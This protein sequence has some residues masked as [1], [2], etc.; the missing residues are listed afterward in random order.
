MST[1]VAAVAI[2]C[3]VTTDEIQNEARGVRQRVP[4]TARERRPQK[5]PQRH[6][7]RPRL[8]AVSDADTQQLVATEHRR[9]RDE[10]AEQ[11]GHLTIVA[12]NSIYPSSP[13][14][15]AMAK[16]STTA[17]ERPK[18]LDLRRTSSQSRLPTADRPEV[19][20]TTS[21]AAGVATA[22]RPEDGDRVESVQALHG[23][24]TVKVS[25]MPGSEPRVEPVNRKHDPRSQTP[26]SGVVV[27][28][29]DQRFAAVQPPSAISPDLML[30]AGS[31]GPAFHIAQTPTKSTIVIIRN[32]ASL[33]HVG[34]GGGG[35]VQPALTTTPS[36]TTPRDDQPTPFT[37]SPN[38]LQPVAETGT[39]TYHQ[40]VVGFAATS[41]FVVP[42]T[43]ATAAAAG[44]RP[45]TPTASDEM[46]AVGLNTGVEGERRR[47][48][49]N[50]RTLTAVERTAAMTFQP[51][52]SSNQTDVSEL[53]ERRSNEVSTVEPSLPRNDV[54]LDDGSRQAVVHR[55]AR[56][57]TTEDHIIPPSKPKAST[58][59]AKQRDAKS[60]A[61]A[62]QQKTAALKRAPLQRSKQLQIAA[63]QSEN[64]P[65]APDAVKLKRNS[66]KRQDNDLEHTL[67]KDFQPVKR[68]VA[69][70][71]AVFQ[72]QRS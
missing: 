42:D 54:N 21:G 61:V 23:R 59:V 53:V 35:G 3:D 46:A 25:D 57:R 15:P 37:V 33:P 29:L 31:A 38:V 28:P 6:E 17:A 65:H 30:H 32:D 56:L 18:S 40:P 1:T 22:R 5:E 44:C 62:K 41:K 8:D 71:R 72:G 70:L 64:R 19:T 14:P 4:D 50:V 16:Q 13:P 58:P 45:F 49:V 36:A 43:T 12:K 26:D 2:G 63:K 52:V 34:G 27:S 47:Y 51:D 69:E 60:T 55:P 24:C 67:A 9:G 68:S 39:T 7:T 20:L 10:R 48:V 11:S 66:S